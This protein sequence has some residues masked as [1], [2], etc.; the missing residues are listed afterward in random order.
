MNAYPQTDLQNLIIVD[1]GYPN[2]A[3]IIQKVFKIF[4]E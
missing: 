3:K 4:E 2:D 1:T